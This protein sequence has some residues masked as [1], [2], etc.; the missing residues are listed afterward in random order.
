[1]NDPLELSVEEEDVN[2]E[3]ST[4]TDNK[5]NT[6]LQLSVEEK[7]S[8]FVSYRQHTNKNTYGIKNDVQRITNVIHCTS[9]YDQ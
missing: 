8:L 9:Y 1:M 6:S 2:N 4:S 3:P 5:T 7:D